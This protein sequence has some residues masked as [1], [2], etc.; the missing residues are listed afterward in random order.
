[1]VRLCNLH[2]SWITFVF[3]VRRTLIF[4]GNFHMLEKD[5]FDF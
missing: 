5:T 4:R 3:V 2:C 1:M